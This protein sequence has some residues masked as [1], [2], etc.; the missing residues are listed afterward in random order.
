MRSDPQKTGDWESQADPQRGH[1][2]IKRTDS[3]L[4]PCGPAQPEGFGE[5]GMLERGRS[6]REARS[7]KLQNAARSH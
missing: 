6:T 7:L 4:I 3:D 5:V 2:V 1:S